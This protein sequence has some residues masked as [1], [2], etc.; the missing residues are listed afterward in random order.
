VRRRNGRP[1]PRAAEPSAGRLRPDPSRGLLETILVK[2]GRPR[3]LDEHLDRLAGSLCALYGNT[4]QPDPQKRLLAA[5]ALT[6]DG[7]LRV[8]AGHDG[9]LEVDARRLPSR[10][11][12]VRLNAVAL[13]GG[14]GPHKWA[15]RRLLDALTVAGRTPLLVDADGSVLEAAWGN[16]WIRVGNRLLTPP[17]DGRI[18]PG[19]TRGLLLHDRRL[20]AEEQRIDLD[21]LMRAEAVLISSSLTGLLPALLEAGD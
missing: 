7:A 17:A 10:A 12:P 15:D 13:P 19:V 4:L 5:A 1:A 8:T 6:G 16:V 3:H 14:L 9:H 2:G 21:S 20:R 11:I 18:L